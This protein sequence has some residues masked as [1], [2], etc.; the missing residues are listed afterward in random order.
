MNSEEI[1]KN[2]IIRLNSIDSF[3]IINPNDINGLNDNSKKINM[4]EFVQTQSININTNEELIYTTILNE[5][6]DILNENK[7]LFVNSAISKPEIKF[8]NK[9]TYWINFKKNCSQ[10]NR[11]TEQVQKFIE[12]ELSTNSSINDKG[13]LLLRGRY[14]FANISK[15][16]KM[17]IKYYVQCSTCKSFNTEIFR[18]TSNRLDYLKCLNI[19]PRC[20]TCKVV[21]KL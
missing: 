14:D 6:Y 16:F 3:K 2:Q 21:P 15:Q 4:E 13:Q 17:Y 20:N 7:E 1:E 18:N 19:Q 12:K 5:I 9:K 11:T 10:I 8:E